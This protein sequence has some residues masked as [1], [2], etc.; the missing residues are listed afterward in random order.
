MVVEVDVVLDVVD[1]LVDVEGAV[2]TG[3]VVDVVGAVD[4]EVTAA[5]DEVEP[6]SV[7]VPPSLL[8][9]AAA[10]A[11][12]ATRTKGVGFTPGSL[13]REV[14]FTGSRCLL[15]DHFQQAVIDL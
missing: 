3:I 4:V 8:Q 12:A 2:V 14:S 6:E 7:V 15:R 10:R 11:R 13:A 1:V 9:A 5:V